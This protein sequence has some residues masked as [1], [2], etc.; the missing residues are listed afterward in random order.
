MTPSLARLLNSAS[1]FEVDFERDEVEVA[2]DL[3]RGCDF[4]RREGRGVADMIE[5]MSGEAERAGDGGVCDFEGNAICLAVLVSAGVDGEMMLV[6]VVPAGMG[7]K[8]SEGGE[9]TGL[10]GRLALRLR[11]ICL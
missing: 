11:S 7:G 2:V 9:E 3:T 5:S 1:M 8:G 4:E 6:V 10:P